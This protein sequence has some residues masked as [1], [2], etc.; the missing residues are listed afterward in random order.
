MTVKGQAHVG[1]LKDVK[2]ITVQRPLDLNRFEVEAV[3]MALS[4]FIA[5]MT[6]ELDGKHDDELD[7]HVRDAQNVLKRLEG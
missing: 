1:D 2:P 7:A 6:E 5:V 4:M 3:G